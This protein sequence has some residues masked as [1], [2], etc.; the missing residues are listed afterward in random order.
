MLVAVLRFR[1]LRDK[2]SLPE[3]KGHLADHVALTEEDNVDLHWLF[4]GEDLN[5]GLRRLGDDKTC[6]LMIESITEGGV[7]K[8]YVEIFKYV[9]DEVVM[10][11]CGQPTADSGAAIQCSPSKQDT[12][13]DIGKLKSFYSSPLKQSETVQHDDNLDRQGAGSY[14]EEETSSDDEGAEVSAADLDDEE[15]TDSEDGDYTVGDS[16]TSKDDE[17]AKH[18][19]AKEEPLLLMLELKL[20]HIFRYMKVMLIMKFLTPH[21]Q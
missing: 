15:D 6:L 20:C 21:P 2:V 7:A 1:T 12:L 8:I 9:G 3:I 11:S 18:F 17:E 16:D 5:S 14:D 4:P 19:R 13:R 10:W